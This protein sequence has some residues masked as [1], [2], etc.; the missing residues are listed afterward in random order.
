MSEEIDYMNDRD[1]NVFLN[2]RIVNLDRACFRELE[3][4]NKP[5]NPTK[6]NFNLESYNDNDGNFTQSL[7][8]I[9]LHTTFLF[10]RSNQL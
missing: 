9:I 6:S 8:I 7:Y 2:P 10:S 3:A 1:P 5:I 4:Y